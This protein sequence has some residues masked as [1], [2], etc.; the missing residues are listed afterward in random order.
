[1]VFQA[2]PLPNPYNDTLVFAVTSPMFWTIVLSAK[3]GDVS[4][5]RLSFT[6]QSSHRM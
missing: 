4:A 3:V 6:R 1:M 2:T 5:N